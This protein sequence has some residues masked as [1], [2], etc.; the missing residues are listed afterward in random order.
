MK[1]II[2]IAPPAAGKGTMSEMVED[3]YNIPHI[4]TGA[5]LREVSTQDNELGREVKGLNDS[6]QF[7]DD[8]L[9]IKLIEQR[10]SQSDC[11]NGFILD[12]FPRTVYQAGEYDKLLEKLNKDLGVVILL[13]ISKEEAMKRITGRLSCSKCNKIYNIHN[14]EMTPKKENICDECGSELTTRADDNE[15]TFEKRFN[16][17]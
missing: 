1:N 3:K 6:G 8:N 13:E 4:S 11:D 14:P 9:M 12:G 10:I 17:Y 7:V 15:E 5:L 2:F 16:T